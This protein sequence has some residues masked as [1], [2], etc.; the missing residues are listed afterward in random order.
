VAA[1]YSDYDVAYGTSLALRSLG[2]LVVTTRD[3]GQDAATDD[4]QLL[5]AATNGWVLI[6]HNTDDFV[7]LHRAWQSW[8]AAWGVAAV[9]SGILVL[10][11][12]HWNANEQAEVLDRFLRARGSVV[13][14]AHIC[15]RAEQWSLVVL[16]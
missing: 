3:V 7:L 8:T 14:E 11:P 1:L 2:H 10:P 5:I 12:Q 16:R 9:H 4:R 13:N 6:T 15:D